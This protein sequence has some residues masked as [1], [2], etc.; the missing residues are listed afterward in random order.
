MID[1]LVINYVGKNDLRKDLM[2][3]C[4]IC[5]RKEGI[6]E[7]VEIK[8]NNIGGKNIENWIEGRKV[9]EV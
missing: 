7:K 2:M 9:V 3:K 4:G 8:R 1:M 5:D 6:K